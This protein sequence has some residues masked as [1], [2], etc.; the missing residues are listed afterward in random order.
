MTGRT[1]NWDMIT[2]RKPY[3]KIMANIG[4]IVLGLDGADPLLGSI[5]NRKYG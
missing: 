1:G 5:Y 3:L 2:M 4:G